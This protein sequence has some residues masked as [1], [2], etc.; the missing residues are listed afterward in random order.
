M[1]YGIS[2]AVLNGVAAYIAG[3]Q[4]RRGME[5]EMTISVAKLREL[6]VVGPILYPGRL[7]TIMGL[8]V[9]DPCRYCGRTKQ[10]T[11]HRN[12]DGCG[13]PN[14]SRSKP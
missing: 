4:Q 8:Q 2:P 11:H 7:T 9:V 3:L 6:G 10:S 5:A 1:F 13:A 14:E 12:C